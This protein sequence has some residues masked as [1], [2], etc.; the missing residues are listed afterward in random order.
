MSSANALDG[1]EL[2][3]NG[4]IYVSELLRR[5]IW[6][7]SPDS[8]QRSLIASK[9]KRPTGQQRKSALEGRG[10]VFSI[11][12][13]KPQEADRTVVCMKSFSVPK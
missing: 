12:D 4:N 2:D 1:I 5:A 13:Q 11:T 10:P 6:V 7:L 8:S 9:A 3:D